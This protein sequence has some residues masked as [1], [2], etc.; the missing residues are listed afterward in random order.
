M[1]DSSCHSHL[2]DGGQL[3][4]DGTAVGQSSRVAGGSSYFNQLQA[5]V[6]EWTHGGAPVPRPPVPLFTGGLFEVL[7]FT[8]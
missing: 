7:L 5:L 4:L 3:T 1:S 8:H 2:L 6:S